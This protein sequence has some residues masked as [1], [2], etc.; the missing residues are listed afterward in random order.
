MKDMRLPDALARPLQST[1]QSL[2]ATACT[3]ATSVPQLSAGLCALVDAVAQTR[4]IGFLQMLALVS[5]ACQ[6]QRRGA[7]PAR[8]FCLLR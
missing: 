4:T 3:L 7:T 6:A 2:L 1:L 8:S 5:T